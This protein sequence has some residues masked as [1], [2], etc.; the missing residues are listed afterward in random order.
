MCASSDRLFQ[1]WPQRK[2]DHRERI[3]PAEFQVQHR[4]LFHATMMAAIQKNV[5][6][7]QDGLA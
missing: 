6:E 4:M 2:R 3:V 5:Q 7:T 1:V